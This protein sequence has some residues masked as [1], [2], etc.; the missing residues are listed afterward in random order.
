MYDIRNMYDI[1]K[2]Y[3]IRNIYDMRNMYDIRNKYDVRNIY[4][5]RN[6]HDIR[7]MYDIRSMY[8]IRIT[9]DI[10]N[11]CVIYIVRSKSRTSPHRG[12]YIVSYYVRNQKISITPNL[13]HTY[14]TTKKSQITKKFWPEQ[15]SLHKE[16]SQITWYD[17]DHC[18]C[19]S[20]LC[21]PASVVA[22][23]G[24][25]CLGHGQFTG[26]RRVHSSVDGHP[27]TT[28]QQVAAVVPIQKP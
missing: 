27:R 22:G 13:K 15:V 4:G 1:R 9:Y 21:R 18:R 5:I 20:E 16:T 24:L 14:I 28:L 23:V 26:D 19:R 25:P 7:N 3:D 17:M 12:R 6:I 8:D 11:I 10:R 2:M